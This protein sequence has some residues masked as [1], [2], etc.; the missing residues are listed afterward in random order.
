MSA[1]RLIG[2]DTF[3]KTAFSVVIATV[4]LE[5]VLILKRCMHVEAFTKINR[6]WT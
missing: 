2:M 3:M 4:E 1:A 6:E 5:K